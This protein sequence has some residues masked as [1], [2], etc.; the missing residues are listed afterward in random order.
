MIASDNQKCSYNRDIHMENKQKKKLDLSIT[1]LRLVVTVGGLALIGLNEFY[2]WNIPS[3]GF[4]V[5][6]AIM[7]SVFLTQKKGV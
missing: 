6:L 2:Q 5:I 1:P 3:I 4:I 7:A